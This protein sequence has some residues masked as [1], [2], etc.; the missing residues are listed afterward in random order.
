M[1]ELAATPELDVRYTAVATA[2]DGRDGRVSTDDGA[3]DLVV[4]PQQN[5]DYKVK[6]MLDTLGGPGPRGGTVT[7][8]EQL[9]AAGYCASFHGA[10]GAVAVVAKVDVTGSQV[11]AKVAVC[12]DED[13]GLRL[14]VELCVSV[15]DLDA[16][17][18]AKLA[19]YA[20]QIDPYSI[21]MR[22]NIDVRLT[23]V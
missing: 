20:H 3:L 13:E 21:A 4:R 7:N 8:P 10:V 22:G 19:K 18:V 23:V 2:Q 5:V 9:F 14:Q 6:S 11:T 16:V 17:T 1:P 15:P 12:K